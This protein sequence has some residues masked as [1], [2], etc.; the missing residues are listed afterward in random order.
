MNMHVTAFTRRGR[1][2]GTGIDDRDTIAKIEA[3][4]RRQPGLSPTFVI[5][6]MLRISNP[7]TI[8]RLRDKLKARHPGFVGRA[9][10]R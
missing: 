10:Q 3:I 8:R 6:N 9:C 5:R 1:P 2:K 4:L 7:S